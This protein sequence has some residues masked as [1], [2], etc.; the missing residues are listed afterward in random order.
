MNTPNL[1][2]LSSFG[3]AIATLGEAITA[4]KETPANKFIRDAAIQ[5]FEYTYELCNKMLRRYLSLTEPSAE[6]VQKMS[7]PTLI[8]TGS[9]RGLLLNAWDVWRQ[10]REARNMTSHTYDEEIAMRVIGAVPSFLDDA[11]YLF[12]QIQGRIK[13]V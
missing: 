11:K 3:K 13:Q 9:E 6:E 4:L 8:R 7:F 5:R 10:Y 12:N 2:D 1:L